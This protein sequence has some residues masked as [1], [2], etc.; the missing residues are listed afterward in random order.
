MQENTN[1]ANSDICTNIRQ[2]MFLFFSRIKFVGLDSHLY[3]REKFQYKLTSLK[4]TVNGREKEIPGGK[5]YLATFEPVLS[6]T[7][8]TVLC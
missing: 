4:P 5:H 2:K 3:F 8:L 6:I 1:V 7:S